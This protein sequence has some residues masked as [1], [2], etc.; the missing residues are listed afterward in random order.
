[1]IPSLSHAE[2]LGEL[3]RDHPTAAVAGTHGKTTTTALIAWLLDRAGLEPTALIGGA[4]LNFPSGIRLGEG[5]FVVE[6]DEYDRRFLQ[7]TPEVAVVTNVEADHLDYYRDLDEI[8]AAF[9]AFV[10]R[11]P[12]HGRLVVCVDDPRAA[13]L[14]TEAQ[15]ETFGASDLADWQVQ[16]Y[17]PLPD[18][19]SRFV[20]HAA[21]RGWEARSRLV[22]WHNALNA[23]AALAVADHFGVGLRAALSALAEFKGTRR[24]F[25]TRGRP[26]G[27]WVVDDYAHHP[28]EVR[29]VLRAARERVPRPSAIWAVFQPHSVNRTAALFDDFLSAF[30]EADHVLVLPIY[31]PAGREQD[32]ATSGALAQ[33]LVDAMR[34][35]GH[36]D[37][38]LVESF[39]A[40][41]SAIVDGARPG[42]LVLTFGAGDVTLL[43]DRLVAALDGSQRT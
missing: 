35:H 30:D 13:A 27:I 20:V 8:E 31:R 41:E 40:A 36:L 4:A 6:A 22:G 34:A 21:G 10:D 37:A 38:R 25:E 5:P 43:A 19:G 14:H 12:R 3:T 33:R 32:D 15:R 16:D 28:S 42:D 11:L 17:A 26:G 7:L 29:T 39:D 23:T 2:A 9:Q 18:G 24:R 1:G